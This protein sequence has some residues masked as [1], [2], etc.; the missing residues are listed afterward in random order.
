MRQQPV[1]PWVRSSYLEKLGRHRDDFGW[2]Q[3][4]HSGDEAEVNRWLELFES[5]G[6][7]PQLIQSHPDLQYALAG[8]RSELP[9]TKDRVDALIGPEA[10]EEN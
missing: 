9:A 7:L 6:E 1:A 3:E 2:M 5:L 4:F 8:I 10:G